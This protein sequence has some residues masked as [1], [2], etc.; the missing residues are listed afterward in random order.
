MLQP[1]S[2]DR[3]PLFP[4]VACAAPSKIAIDGFGVRRLGATPAP[5]TLEQEAAKLKEWLGHANIATT[6]IYDHQRHRIAK[7]K[8]TVKEIR[9]VSAGYRRNDSTSSASPSV[10]LLSFI[11][12]N[13]VDQSLIEDRRPP[14]P[15]SRCREGPSDAGSL[16]ASRDE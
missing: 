13:V 12:K 7:L 9:P 10:L 6:R 15:H 5:N 14:R 1:L 4:A 11:L 2:G 3:R 16:C 8:L